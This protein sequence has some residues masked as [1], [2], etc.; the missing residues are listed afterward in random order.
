MPVILRGITVCP[1]NMRD[2]FRTLLHMQIL[3]EANFTM[4]QKCPDLWHAICYLEPEHN[5]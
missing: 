4:G 2:S 1:L 5:V 3:Q